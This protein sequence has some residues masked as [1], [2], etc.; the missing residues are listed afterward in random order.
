MLVTCFFI[1]TV[2]AILGCA[3]AEE[4]VSTCST[5]TNTETNFIAPDSGISG[6]STADTG[7]VSSS[8]THSVGYWIWASDV[9]DANAELLNSKGITDV[10]VLT[11]GVKGKTYNAELQEA[12][13]K[14]HPYGI[15]VHSWIVCF[16]DGSNEHFVNPSGYYSYTKKVYV[17]TIKTWGKKKKAYRVW[18]RVKWKKVNGKW[19][20]KWKKVIRY[21]WKKGWIYTPVYRYETVKGYSSTHNTNL[22]N[23]I[24]SVATNYD[25]DGI[26]LDYVRYSGVASK[27]HAAWQ[28]PG[29]VTAAVNAVTGFVQKVNDNIKSVKPNIILSAAVMPDGE[30]N[31]KY[32]GQDYAKLG[33]IVDYL[34][35]MIYKGNYKQDTEWIGT[36]TAKIIELSGNRTVVA[37]L[38]TYYSDSNVQGIPRDEL[39]TDINTAIG[40]GAS[41]VVLFRYEAH[42]THTSDITLY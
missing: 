40:N 33:S 3:Y 4:D 32:Y 27:N 31:A 1:I 2:I 30:V 6:C 34:V 15:R 8:S 21:K 9:H 25:V 36:T 26:H 28:E 12:I 19:R 38:Q 18:K 16:K 37:G 5:V 24:K 23:Y 10:Y 20:Y 41:G 11:R 13:T 14:F 17:K 29:G 42:T 39:I 22:I 35:P 7:T